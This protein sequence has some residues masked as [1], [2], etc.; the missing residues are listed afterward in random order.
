MRFSRMRPYAFASLA[1]RELAHVRETAL[2]L[3]IEI[4]DRAGDG[5]ERPDQPAVAVHV[6]HQPIV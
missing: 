3:E 1:F 2:T 5:D 6:L 4:G